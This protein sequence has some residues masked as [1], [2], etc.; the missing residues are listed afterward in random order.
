MIKKNARKIDE[1]NEYYRVCPYC[2]T[3]FMAIHLSRWYCPEKHG[4]RNY[5][6]NRHKTKIKNQ[7]L[8]FEY[9]MGLKPDVVE[10]PKVE[11]EVIGEDIR[12]KHKQILDALPFR[13]DGTI[14]IEVEFLEQKGLNF[15]AYDS[16][17]SLPNH[18]NLFYLEYGD[19]YLMWSSGK[20]I[21][22]TN[23]NNTLW[24]QNY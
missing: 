22:I 4:I 17:G 10:L 13:R 19:Y 16:R 5:C 3:A 11:V 24:M 9:E 23:Q 18:P 7:K 2:Q 15:N 1:T 14:E 6:L 20:K 21:F 12:Q 8:E